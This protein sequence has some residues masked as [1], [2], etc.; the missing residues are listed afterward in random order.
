MKRDSLEKIVLP[1]VIKDAAMRGVSFE[2]VTQIIIRALGAA[3]PVPEAWIS[4][5]GIVGR[6]K[7]MQ[8]EGGCVGPTFAAQLFKKASENHA[9]VQKLRAAARAHQIIAL[10][11][12]RSVLFPVWQFAESGGPLRGL[13]RVLKV[14]K[15]GPGYSDISPVSFFL[16]PHPRLDETP[17]KAL[18]AGK[19]REVL[20]AA[21]ADLF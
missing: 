16:Q 7:I 19:V 15:Q 1:A 17:L 8:R 10:R 21:E 2:A 20:E 4:V 3:Y 5:A 9:S 18:R 14:L 6:R 11:N 13:D 12:G